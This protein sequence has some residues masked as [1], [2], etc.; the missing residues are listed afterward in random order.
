MSELWLE[1]RRL[2]RLAD[3]LDRLDKLKAFTFR[4][5]DGVSLSWPWA[6]AHW[7]EHW[8]VMR[9]DLM[10]MLREG[11]WMLRDELIARLERDIAEMRAELAGQQAPD[12]SE[13]A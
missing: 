7:A 1:A 2:R 11:W 8:A 3:A 9:G 10:G 4:P 13:G 6:E 5:D 12:S